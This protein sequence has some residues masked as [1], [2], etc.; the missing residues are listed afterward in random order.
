MAERWRRP[1]TV[2]GVEDSNEAFVERDG[3]IR[4]GIKVIFDR[5]STERIRSGYA[6]AKCLEVWE[7]AWPERCPTCGAPIR[8]RQ[9][10]YFAREFEVR[11][12]LRVDPFVDGRI[13]ERAAKAR[14]EDD[15]S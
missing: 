13:H 14:E 7:R 9:L 3:T 15:G 6:C 11:E 4:R 8:E 2:L 5:E 1:L 10:E 12:P